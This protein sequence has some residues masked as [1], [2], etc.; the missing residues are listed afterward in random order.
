MQLK[1]LF[2]AAVAPLTFLACSSDD[3]APATAEATGTPILLSSSV[4]DVTRAATNIQNDKLDQ[5]TVVDVQIVDKNDKGTGA[6]TTY[7]L[8]K[9]QVTDAGG[10]LSPVKKINPYYPTSGSKVDIYAVYPEGNLDVGY[11]E[12]QPTQLGKDAYKASDLMFAKVEDQEAQQG[13]V[14]LNFKHLM[15]KVVVK[16]IKGPNGENIKKSTVNLLNIATKINL[17]G[18]GQLGTVDEASRSTI[19]MS[20][21]GSVT[22]AAIIVPQSVPKGVLIEVLLANNDIVNYETVQ[23]VPFES[24]KVYTYNITVVESKLQVKTE[25]KDW[26]ETE[27]Q[28]QD[29]TLDDNFTGEE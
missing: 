14:K 23:D 2:F 8:L 22:S 28:A 24:G 15:S 9:Y 18:R 16:L 1:N 12:I 21:D 5:K 27:D 3:T 17:A 19:Q 26:I 7:D 25:V 10:T 4:G 6:P 11:F 20:T 29:T 13:A